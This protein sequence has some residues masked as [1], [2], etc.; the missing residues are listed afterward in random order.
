MKRL[1]LL[2]L[3]F[4]IAFAVFF[5]APAFLS[6]QLSFYPLMKAGDLLDIFTPLALIPLYWL[7]FRNGT[8]KA[9]GTM[10]TV[11]FFVLAALWIEGQGMHLAANSIGHFLK[12]L[13][14][15]DAYSLANFYDEV[16]SHY[17]WH[18]G[19]MGLS[20]LLVLRQW[21]TPLTEGQTAKWM[22]GL[23]GFIYGFTF[24]IIIIEGATTAFGVPF[25]TLFTLFGLIWGR[26]KL[27]QR[28]ILLFFFVAYL[29]AAIFFAGWAIYWRGLPE[30]SQVGII[31]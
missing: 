8:D 25:A 9:P 6:K 18:G 3:I 30:F 29:T 24:F 17:M 10:E 2:T 4:S 7:L 20:L 19:V 11:T 12:G 5:I 13:T 1:P 21:R 15:T 16:L 23:A 26:N 22:P 31:D 27:K 28:P 14:G